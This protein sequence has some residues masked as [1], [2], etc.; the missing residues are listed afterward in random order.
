MALM[1]EVVSLTFCV[2]VLVGCTS[3]PEPE[4]TASTRRITAEVVGPDPMAPRVMAQPVDSVRGRVLSVNP[5]LRFV[6]VDF[7]GH[8]MPQLDEKLGVWRLDYKVAEITVSGPYRGST[9]A[10]DITAGEVLPGDMVRPER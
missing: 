6:I 7:P 2:A 10:A 1:R 9:V 8:K 5:A 4:Q 3:T